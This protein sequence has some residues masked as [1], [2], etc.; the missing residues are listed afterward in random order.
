MSLVIG[1]TG[2][3]ASGKSTTSKYIKEKGYKVIDCDQISHNILLSG[4]CGYNALV[5]EFGNEILEDNEISRVKLGSIVF[6]DKEKLNTLNSILHPLIYN[7]VKNQI[8]EDLVFID[9]P[10]LFET[11]FIELCNKTLVVYVDKETQLDR[12]MKRNNMNK[13]E[14]LNR[15]N[16][17]LSLEEK[18]NRCDYIIDNTKSIDDLHNQINEFLNKL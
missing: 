6:N 10:L 4:N 8:N 2:G 13:E 15:I 11:N 18:K 5:N 12:L 9:C 14:A 1:L 3:I 16:L 17:Q 7:E